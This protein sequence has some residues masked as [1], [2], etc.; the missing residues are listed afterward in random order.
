M[1][2]QMVRA[3]NAVSDDTKG[4]QRP[5]TDDKPVQIGPKSKRVP[6]SSATCENCLCPIEAKAPDLPDEPEATTWQPPIKA[7]MRDVTSPGPLGAGLVRRQ[8]E[9]GQTGSR[10]GVQET[11][12]YN[13]A[14][15]TAFRGERRHYQKPLHQSMR[16]C[17]AFEAR[18]LHKRLNAQSQPIFE[19]SIDFDPIAV[20]D[21]NL[22][23]KRV[24][25]WDSWFAFTRRDYIPTL[26][27]VSNKVK[28]CCC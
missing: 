14:P 18:A 22:T 17:A 16:H 15:A 28:T 11:A 4:G 23:P 7:T 24:E 8:R 19:V 5:V 12:E 26:S 13:T 2:G 6:N 21:P 25:A 27:R 1:N 20:P 9:P 3:G 10:I